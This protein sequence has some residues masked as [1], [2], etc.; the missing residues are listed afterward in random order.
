MARTQM[1]LDAL[2]GS[3]SSVKSEVSSLD[4]GSLQDVMDHLASGIKRL[5]GGDFYHSQEAGLFS[6][7]IRMGE[8][9]AISGAM[10]LTGSA[11]M[12]DAVIIEGVADLNSHLDVAGNATM[13]AKL[14]VTGAAEMLSTLAVGGNADFDG[15]FDVQGA[16][17]MQA[18]LTV[19]GAGDFNS[20]LDVAG[21]VDL[22][23]TGVGTNVR[24]NLSV[25]EDAAI[26]GDL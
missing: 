9:L 26:S 5:H 21:Q 6:Q 12:L 24:G 11:H 10:A 15:T 23:A 20:T 17:N 2:T 18:G 7:D 4:A 22:A 13:G 25:A 14:A 19:A 1:R 3:L 8:R 16:A